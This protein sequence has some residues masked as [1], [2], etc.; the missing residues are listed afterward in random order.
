MDSAV[1]MNTDVV[2]LIGELVVVLLVTDWLGLMKGT[3]LDVM[4]LE[5]GAVLVVDAL[6]DILAVKIALV[7][8]DGVVD[9][10]VIVRVRPV[11]EVLLDV[12][13]VGVILLDVELVFVKD[14][15]EVLLIVEVTLVDDVPLDVELVF[16]P[17]VLV[18]LLK[19]KVEVVNVI[20]LDVEL[21]LVKDVL[22]V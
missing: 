12:A 18:E 6:G 4:L 1:V 9:L 7:V 8:G 13:L 19:V 20:L 16:V 5:V 15:L 22:V 11:L 2:V 14:V 10:L 17:E 3:P 21:V